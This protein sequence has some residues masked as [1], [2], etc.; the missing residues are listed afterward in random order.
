MRRTICRRLS[1]P[2]RSTVTW[3]HGS[4]EVRPLRE[5]PAVEVNARPHTLQQQG[6]GCL[7][8]YRRGPSQK[9]VIRGIAVQEHPAG[10]DTVFGHAVEEPPPG[11]GG[12]DRSESQ[13]PLVTDRPIGIGVSEEHPRVSGKAWD[14]RCP[15]FGWLD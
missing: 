12:A 5:V 6:G 2:V 8:H 14:T 11:D 9:P 7:S 10:I 4:L 13:S 1:G 3:V 15:A